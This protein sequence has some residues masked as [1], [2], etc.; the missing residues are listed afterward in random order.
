VK[1]NLPVRLAC[2]G[3][4]DFLERVEE[5]EFE[6]EGLESAPY[7]SEESCSRES[8]VKNE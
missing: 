4:R 5:F 1:K 2:R 8:I 6:R 3:G 7:V